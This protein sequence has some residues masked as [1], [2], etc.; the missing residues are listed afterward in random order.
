[1]RLGDL[2]AIVANFIW[3]ISMCVFGYDLWH[4][5]VCVARH[6]LKHFYAETYFVAYFW[7]L[8]TEGGM[9]LKLWLHLWQEFTYWHLLWYNIVC[10][11]F[12][13]F[14][15]CCQLVLIVISNNWIYEFNCKIFSYYIRSGNADVYKHEIPGGQYTNLQFQVW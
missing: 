13:A 1:M 10:G 6:Y 12:Y 15:A 11:R 4:L 7:L 2:I 5:I 3:T 9:L 8:Y 14:M